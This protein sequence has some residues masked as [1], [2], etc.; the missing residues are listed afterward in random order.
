M[1]NK[2][3]KKKNQSL[4]CLQGRRVVDTDDFLSFHL[5]P[6]KVFW[7]QSTRTTCPRLLEWIAYVYKNE[8]SWCWNGWQKHPGSLL[9]GAS[10]PWIFVYHWRECKWTFLDAFLDP[11]VR[12]D[13]FFWNFLICLYEMLK[14]VG[15]RVS[16]NDAGRLN[17]GVWIASRVLQRRI[18][19]FISQPMIWTDHT[20]MRAARWPLAFTFAM[21]ECICIKMGAPF[22]MKICFKSI[23]AIL[24]ASTYV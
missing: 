15:L 13:V 1:V 23:P 8:E 10:T 3:F 6:C 19:H 24:H 22:S 4:E 17:R 16:Q 5:F 20:M 9:A 7:W 14:D 12:L 11:Q 2:T 21:L 18:K